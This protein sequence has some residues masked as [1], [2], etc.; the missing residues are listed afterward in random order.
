MK[1]KLT[2]DNFCAGLT[3]VILAMIAG[4]LFM[5]RGLP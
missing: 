4:L 2:E 1:I 3:V 5:L